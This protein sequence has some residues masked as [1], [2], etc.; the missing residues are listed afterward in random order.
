MG[1]G[2]LPRAH[3]DSTA[4]HFCCFDLFC[5]VRRINLLQFTLCLLSSP[6]HH[7]SLSLS[8]SL[9]P[10]LSLSSLS[11]PSLLSP[12]PFSSSFPPLPL[13]PSP[14]LPPSL[15]T[16][17]GP[18]VYPPAKAEHMAK[19]RV[20]VEYS[21][22]MLEPVRPGAV[23]PDRALCLPTFS[24]FLIVNKTSYYTSHLSSPW[25]PRH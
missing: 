19:R 3:L 4:R 5:S 23:L 24:H 9:S 25:T 12:P 15:R 2:N 10:S 18:C 14:S 20:R 16:D 13:S 6:S 8:L 7:L 17:G 21:L 11:P 1:Q 22:S